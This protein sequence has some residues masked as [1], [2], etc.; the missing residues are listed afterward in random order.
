MKR[1]GPD[2]LGRDVLENLAAR[3]FTRR[4]VLRVA[5]LAG[6]SATLPFGSERALAQLSNAGALPDDAVK[7]NANEFPDGPSE[8]AL[9]A[10]AE[11]A[12]RGNRYQY[13]ETDGL[14]QAAA[15]LEGLKPEHFAVYPGSSLALHHAVIAFTSPQRPWWSP[16]RH[17]AAGAA[18]TFI[19]APSSAC[20]CAPPTPRTT[21]RR[22]WRRRTAAR[23]TVLR[24][25]PQQSDWHVTPRAEIEAL[26]A[27][28]PHATP[29]C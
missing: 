10:L 16:S 3:G 29:S 15:A 14:V 12:R 25:Q 26:V 13:P 6:A 5:A 11:A 19:G 23:G 4:H 1:A 21:C 24:V 9:A 18:A 28:A 17:E 20:R 7:I 27:A 2:E 22:C 8:R